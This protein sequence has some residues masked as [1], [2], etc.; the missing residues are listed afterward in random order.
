MNTILELIKSLFSNI[1]NYFSVRKQVKDT[2]AANIEKVKQEAK[3]IKQEAKQERKLD[4]KFERKKKSY[5]VSKLK[6]GM[7]IRVNIN[8]KWEKFTYVSHNEK[9]VTTSTGDIFPY[10]QVTNYHMKELYYAEA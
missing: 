8:G 1:S 5:L 7:T 9:G 2:E 3:T 10:G 6:Q 4:A